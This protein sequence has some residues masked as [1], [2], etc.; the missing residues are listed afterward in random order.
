MLEVGRPRLQRRAIQIIAN[1]QLPIGDLKKS[2]VVGPTNQQSAI[3]IRQ[4]AMIRVRILEMNVQ[5]LDKRIVNN[6]FYRDFHRN[7]EETDQQSGMALDLPVGRRIYMSGA[8]AE[9]LDEL[10]TS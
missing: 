9:G 7:C 4:L 8:L 3:G 1:C 2:N 5:M 6:N 10:A